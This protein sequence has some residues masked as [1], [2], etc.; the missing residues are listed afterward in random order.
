MKSIENT[1]QT[2]VVEECPSVESSDQSTL[3]GNVMHSEPD[4][5]ALFDGQKKHEDILDELLQEFKPLNIREYLKLPSDIKEKQ[6]YIVVAVVKHLLEQAKKKQWNLAKVNDTTYLYNGA[7]WQQLD[8][9]T[10]KAFLGKVAVKIGYSDF[11][12]RH[13]QFKDMLLK[14][15]F[16][17]CPSSFSKCRPR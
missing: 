9:D 12:A 3:D 2:I 5:I 17:R 8:K 13:F 1:V 6:K 11:E 14:Q 10:L 7:Y 16:N 15:F 4:G